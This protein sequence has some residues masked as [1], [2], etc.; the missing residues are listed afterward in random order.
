MIVTL[1]KKG[2]WHIHYG[3]PHPQQH[4]KIHKLEV[5]DDLLSLVSYVIP[6]FNGKF[7]PRA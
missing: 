5:H 3:R 4:A 7:D 2:I 6:C 1:K